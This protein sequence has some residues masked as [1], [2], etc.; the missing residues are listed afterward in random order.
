MVFQFA[1][2]YFDCRV[3]LSSSFLFRFFY[4]TTEKKNEY[5]L[6]KKNVFFCIFKTMVEAVCATC[7][8]TGYPCCSFDFEMSFEKGVLINRVP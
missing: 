7:I 6:K 3:C 8:V 4:H 5:N 1:F 2:F